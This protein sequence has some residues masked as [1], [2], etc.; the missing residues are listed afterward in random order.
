MNNVFEDFLLI[1]NPAKCGSS[2][3]AHGLT[4]RPFMTFPREFDFLFFLDFPLDR[5][6]NDETAKDEEFLG[7]RNDDSLTPD[8]KL[9]RL[10]EIERNRRSEIGML[11]DKAPSN[12]HSFLKFRH[13]FRD[14]RT[15]V[16]YRDP[17]DIYISNELFH[18]RQLE[19][20]DRHDD[21]GS[22]DYLRRSRVF[23][24]SMKS[25]EQVYR[26]E[27]Q[28]RE[29][30]VDYLRI[31][32]EEMKKDFVDV[33]TRVIE[34]SGVEIPADA[35]VHSH[36]VEEHIPFAEHL[37]RAKDFK[38]LFRKGIIGDW[39]NHI[40]TD[41]AREI[42]KERGGELLVTLGYEQGLDW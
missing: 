9:R 31:T 22:A 38:P 8:Q 41:E 29:D 34:F 7:V 2:W 18:Q 23:E 11:V 25:C 30:G 28:L 32:Y 12:V 27:T 37:E 20:V 39:K 40:T 1:L 16:L 19:T 10:Y 36:Y 4:M 15:V 26:A 3:L 5:Q 14:T 6:W 33:L 17:R 21:I 35:L 24:A 13:L 42:V